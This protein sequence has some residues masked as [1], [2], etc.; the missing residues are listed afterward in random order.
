M[1]LLLLLRMTMML[2]R[3]K[4][5]DEDNDDGVYEV[6]PS[7]TKGKKTVGFCIGR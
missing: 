7:V 5:N 6:L 1:L 4:E 2:I 3:A